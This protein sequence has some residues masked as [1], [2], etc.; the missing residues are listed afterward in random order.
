M[1]NQYVVKVIVYV[2]PSCTMCTTESQQCTAYMA[3]YV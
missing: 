2:T 3:P 1:S